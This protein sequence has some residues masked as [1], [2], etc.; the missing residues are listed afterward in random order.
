MKKRRESKDVNSLQSLQSLQVFT[1]VSVYESVSEKE[2]MQGE[3][4]PHAP[5]SESTLMEY[6]GA[7]EFLKLHPAFEK[8]GPMAIENTLKGF[9]AYKQYWPKMLREFQTDNAGTETLKHPPC[10]ELRL[11]FTR[12]VKFNNLP[13]PYQSN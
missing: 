13:S 2:G 4:N 10:Q 1:P 12:Y 7:I 6:S 11:A 8:V 3:I 9:V 5:V